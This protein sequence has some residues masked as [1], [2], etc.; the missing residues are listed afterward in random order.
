MLHAS[1]A[2]AAISTQLP[3]T[4][5]RHS[6]TRDRAKT[7]LPNLK[8]VREPDARLELAILILFFVPGPDLL[9]SCRTIDHTLDGSDTVHTLAGTHTSQPRRGAGGE[10][11]TLQEPDS[12]VFLRIDSAPFDIPSI[13]NPQRPN[14]RRPRSCIVVLRRDSAA[15]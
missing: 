2:Y 13:E 11:R 9:F 12:V 1:A 6:S 5:D 10:R 14:I 7:G 15:R 8:L 3:R 4:C